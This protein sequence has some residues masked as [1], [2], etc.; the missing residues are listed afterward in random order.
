MLLARGFV[1]GKIRNQRTLLRRQLGTLAATELQQ[2]SLLVDR[3]RKA[4]SPDVLLG[5]EG[6]AARVYFSEV[7]RYAKGRDAF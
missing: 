7:R 3:V 1:E 2:L 5:L 6:Q 4:L